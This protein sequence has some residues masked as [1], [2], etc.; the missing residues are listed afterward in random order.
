[1]MY[2]KITLP[3]NSGEDIC[4]KFDKNNIHIENSYK[5]SSTK[6]MKSI[7]TLVN[8]AAEN[9]DIIYKRT[10]K[11]WIKEW[12]AHNILYKFCIK[13]SSSKHV[14][15]NENETRSRLFVYNILSL[16]YWK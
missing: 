8:G 12:Q 1:M 14:D 3:T 6:E 2:Y 11:S 7:L 9:R 10:L 13:P 4:V 16:F 15:L 5:I